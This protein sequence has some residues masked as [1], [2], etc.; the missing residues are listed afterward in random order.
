MPHGCT[1]FGSEDFYLSG[2]GLFKMK[3][4]AGELTFV[5]ETCYE[6]LTRSRELQSVMYCE[7]AVTPTT[8]VVHQQKSVHVRKGQSHEVLNLFDLEFAVHF[9]S[10][11]RRQWG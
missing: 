5:F 7:Q 11:N 9:S 1:P 4:F 3:D 10:A 6:R 8:Y 2:S